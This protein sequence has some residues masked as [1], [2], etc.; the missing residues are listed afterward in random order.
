MVQPQAVGTRLP[1]IKD[2][3]LCSSRIIV[4]HVYIYAV[5]INI[6]TQ[7]VDDCNTIYLVLLL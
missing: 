3:D 7:P 5:Y 6:I 2:I 1:E 4:K